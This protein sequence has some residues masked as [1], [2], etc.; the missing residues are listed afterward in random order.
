MKS[1]LYLKMRSNA[2]HKWDEGEPQIGA[3]TCVLPMSMLSALDFCLRLYL[4]M[5]VT[6]TNV[7]FSLLFVKPVSNISRPFWKQ[8]T[9]SFK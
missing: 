6:R 4:Q 1:V 9:I 8:G 7:Y 5:L 3:P 2:N